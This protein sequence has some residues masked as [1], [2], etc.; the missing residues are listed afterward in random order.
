ME[1]DRGLLKK[2]QLVVPGFRG[3]RIREDLRDS[4]RMLRAELAKRMGLQRSQLEDARRALIRE[5]PMSKALEEMGGVVNTMKR[6]E[7]E[8]LHA[9]VG[10]SGIAADVRMKD[11]E[12]NMLYEYDNSMIE[13]LNFIDEALVKVPEIIR[14]GNDADLRGAVEAVRNRVDGLESRFKRRK[15]AITGTGL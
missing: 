13:S 11:D 9:E 7:G 3:Y 4:D 6:V 12:L 8:V 15:A 5:N 14:S 10:Y 1:D 2:I